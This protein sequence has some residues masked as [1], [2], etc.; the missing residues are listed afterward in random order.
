M[1]AK[2]TARANRADVGN[3][4]FI[5]KLDHVGRM[6]CL[7]VDLTEKRTAHAVG[8]RFN[9][10]GSILD[11]RGGRLTRS[12]IGRGAVVVVRALTAGRD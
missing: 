8:Q 5:L 1:G 2:P 11:D 7:L 10:W 6:G 3:P 4:P 12:T 9:A